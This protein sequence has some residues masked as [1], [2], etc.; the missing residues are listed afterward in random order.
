MRRWG[1]VITAF[2]LCVLVVFLLPGGIYLT[3]D[4]GESASDLLLGL[5]DPEAFIDGTWFA[6]LIVAVLVGAQALLLFLS[7]DISRKRLKPRQHVLLSVAVTAFAV[8]L[9]A[10][11][12]FWSVGVAIWADNVVEEEWLFWASPIAFWIVWGTIFYLYRERVSA[13]LDRTVSWLLNGSVL[14]LL[15][16]V[17]CHIVVRQRGDCSAPIVTGYG[18]ATGVAIMLMAF[19]PSVLFLYQKR[20][21]EYERGRR[22]GP[23]AHRRPISKVVSTL[24]IGAIALFFLLPFD[25]EW[26]LR[27]DL[28]AERSSDLRRDIFD[29][30]AT[31]AMTVEATDGAVLIIL[32]DDDAVAQAHIDLPGSDGSVAWRFSVRADRTDLLAALQASVDHR[33]GNWVFTSGPSALNQWRTKVVHATLFS[34][35]CSLQ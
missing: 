12:V 6:W 32:C 24:A 33:A 26:N 17:P 23:L 14:Q 35:S 19:G 9:L 13:R 22:P 11:S 4:A 8:G 5:F 21:Q 28:P 10:T 31:F 20:L 2:Y 1:I 30:A 3:G 18:I 16:V 7:V 15:I 25:D 29:L 27:F 34:G